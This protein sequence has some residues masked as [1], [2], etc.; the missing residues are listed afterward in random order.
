LSGALKGVEDLVP[1]LQMVWSSHMR[2]ALGGKDSWNTV[3]PHKSMA[4]DSEEP[5]E[6]FQREN[7]NFCKAFFDVW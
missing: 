6:L 4:A 1:S 3:Y 7:I 2:N 5:A